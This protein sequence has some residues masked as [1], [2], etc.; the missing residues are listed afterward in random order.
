MCKKFILNI[1]G[2]ATPNTKVHRKIMPMTTHKKVFIIGN[3]FDLSLGLKTSYIDFIKSNVFREK[4]G[5]NKI[6]IHLSNVIR[7]KNW[8]DIEVQLEHLSSSPLLNTNLKEEYEILRRALH[9]YIKSVE[10]SSLNHES[11]AYR[12]LEKEFD[13][14]NSYVINFNYTN[15]VKTILQK[16]RYSA[17]EILKSVHHIH[18]SC[19]D[20][21]IIFGVNDGANIRPNHVFLYKSTMNNSG[22]RNI[23]IALKNA[24]RIMFFGHSLGKSDHMYFQDFFDTLYSGYPARELHFYHYGE[25][26]HLDLHE[27]L[28][29]LTRGNVLK[30]KSQ[31]KFMQHDTSK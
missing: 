8:V 25:E 29:L 15:T 1:D 18:G 2:I 6:L 26:G 17:E 4:I 30:L 7:A 28:Q 16:L 24:E 12:L 5:T 23:D 19:D 31:N 27:K 21:D 11:Q 9:E 13:P 3:G 14:I 20:D 10:N 22:G